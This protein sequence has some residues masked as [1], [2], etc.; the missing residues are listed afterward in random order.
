MI[1]A[2]NFELD[3]FLRSASFPDLAAG[4]HDTPPAVLVTLSRLAFMVLVPMR[5]RFGRLVITSAFRPRALNAAVNGSDSSKHLTGA[6]V[7]FVLDNYPS[8]RAWEEIRDGTAVKPNWDRLAYYTEQNGRFHADINA[9][10]E[11]Q[12]GL[13]FEAGAGG[14]RAV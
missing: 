11:E 4:V 6:A 10:A 3:E 1:V 12:R 14:W 2:P 9:E 7:D 5:E 13:L 8:H